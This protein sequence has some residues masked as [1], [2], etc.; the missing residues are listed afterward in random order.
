MRTT[1]AIA[2]AIVITAGIPCIC[3][4]FCAFGN[5]QTERIALRV[6]LA[7]WVICLAALA[8]LVGAGA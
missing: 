1:V 5:R 8:W 4:P 7:A 3:A 6:G 2:L